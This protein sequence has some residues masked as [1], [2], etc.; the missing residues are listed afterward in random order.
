MTELE[1]QANLAE[2]A[3]T[4]RIRATV[5]E[6]RVHQQRVHQERD[7]AA[8][9]AEEIA[10]AL[11]HLQP[12]IP[13]AQ[14]GATVALA[15]TGACCTTLTVAT[16]ALPLPHPSPLHPDRPTD[17]HARQRS[18]PANAPPACQPECVVATTAT[19][20]GAVQPAAA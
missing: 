3:A 12:H 4:E 16:V 13:P 6:L 8:R 10:A 7:E 20:R 11:L 2:Q 18:R 1:T 17:P 14:H 15:A 19:W 5:S 9:A